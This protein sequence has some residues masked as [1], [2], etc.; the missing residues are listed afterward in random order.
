MPLLVLEVRGA[1]GNG[2][3][4]FAGAMVGMRAGNGVGLREC[5]AEVG[6]E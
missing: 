2:A 4:R 6:L 1:G 3:E 5:E